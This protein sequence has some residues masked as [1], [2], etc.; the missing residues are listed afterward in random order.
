MKILVQ[1]DIFTSKSTLSKI[2]LGDSFFCYGL[3][4]KDRQ[5]EINPKEKIDG[6]TAIPRGRYVLVLDF[7]QRFQCVMPHVLDVPGFTG[8]R[9]H[10]GNTNADTHGCLLVGLSRGQ[11]VVSSSKL[12][13]DAL[14]IRLNTMVQLGQPM[15][16]QYV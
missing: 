2:Y 8:I 15:E 5:L 4:D 10:K 16:I 1:R 9:I 3:E 7:S 12:A 14:M 6:E 11:D 13:Y